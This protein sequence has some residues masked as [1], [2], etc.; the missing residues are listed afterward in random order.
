MIEIFR[1]IWRFAG[2]EQKKHSKLY[3]YRVYQC[4]FSHAADWSDFSYHSG[5]G[6]K[7]S[8]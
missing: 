3:H 4:D 1:K 6:R 8:G 7:G 5:A 2:E